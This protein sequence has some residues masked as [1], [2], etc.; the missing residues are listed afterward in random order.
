MFR[1]ILLVKEIR[2]FVSEI[3]TIPNDFDINVF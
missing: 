3:N 2:K 1:D